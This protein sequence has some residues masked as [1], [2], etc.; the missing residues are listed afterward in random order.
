MYICTY[1]S[2]RRT[3]N[4]WVSISSIEIGFLIVPRTTNVV[5][6]V[7]EGMVFGDV[8]VEIRLLSN[9]I[10]ENAEEEE[11]ICELSYRLSASPAGFCHIIGVFFL[12]APIKYETR[13]QIE[14]TK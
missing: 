9:D 2:V 6:G 11:N 12:S 3:P 1:Q 14:V 5:C 8:E 10:G 13:T 7:Y 4:L